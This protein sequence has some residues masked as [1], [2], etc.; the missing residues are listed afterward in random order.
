MAL[1]VDP[2]SILYDA[3]WTLLEANSGLTA[4]VKVGNRVK[5]ASWFHNPLKDIFSDA[6]LPQVAIVPVGT[7]FNLN[8]TSSSTFVTAR[9]D[10]RLIVGDQRLDQV[11][12]LFAVKWEMLKAMRLWTVHIKNLQW[13]SK[14]YIVDLHTEDAPDEPFIE[15]KGIKGWVSFLRFKVRMVFTTSDL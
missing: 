5:Y 11:G 14:N 3:L 10:A 15:E 7:L 13:N 4:L 9:F 12:G 1:A 8:N 2:F 6:D